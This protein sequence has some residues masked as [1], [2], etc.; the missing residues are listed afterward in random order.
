MVKV[1]DVKHDKTVRKSFSKIGDAMEMPNLI[2][3]QLDSYNW[4]LKEGLGEV[5]REVSPIEDYLGNLVIEFL[6][7][8][9]EE[10]TK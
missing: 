4:F 3:V 6:N 2:K 9:M 1:K 8:R 5:L 10:K 7:Y